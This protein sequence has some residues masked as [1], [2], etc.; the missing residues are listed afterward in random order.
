MKK[1]LFIFVI[2]I[3][4]SINLSAQESA[5]FG[6]T[7]G[8][9]SGTSKVEQFGES[10]SDNQTGF[11]GGLVIELPF[12]EKF[13]LQPEVLYVNINDLSFLQIPIMAKVYVTEALYIQAGPQITYT[14]EQIFDDFTKFN[15]A[16]GGGL[17]YDILPKLFVN[18]KYVF[19]LNNYFTGPQ[20][21]SSKLN[22]FNVGL[23]YKF[24]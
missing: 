9:L 15:L 16:I 23:G 19:Q 14:L 6:I 4:G 13:M 8:Y 11:Y 2:A 24:N 22:F 18:A 10:L 20:D 5:S 3:I 21:I 7:A 1:Q 12:S 17:G